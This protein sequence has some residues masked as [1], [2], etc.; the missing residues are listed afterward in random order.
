MKESKAAAQ[1]I[2]FNDLDSW[3]D[4]SGYS[5]LDWWCWGGEMFE[6]LT[7]RLIYEH[8]VQKMYVSVSMRLFYHSILIS[9][10]TQMY[11][12]ICLGNVSFP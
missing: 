4:A 6:D 8:G 7:G 10:C 1:C 2:R 5:K 9:L 11:M 12:Y 3:W